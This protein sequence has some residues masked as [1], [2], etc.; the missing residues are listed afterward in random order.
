MNLV[1][2]FPFNPIEFRFCG[3]KCVDNEE[4]LKPRKVR[5]TS[6][7]K[8]KYIYA[9]KAL[10]FFY[11][12]FYYDFCNNFTWRE[13]NCRFALNYFFYE[14]KKIF[15][16][17]WNTLLTET[18]TIVNLSF[19]FLFCLHYFASYLKVIALWSFAYLSHQ[20]QKYTMWRID[21][22]RKS[23]HRTVKTERNFWCTQT[24]RR[25]YQQLTVENN[26]FL[27]WFSPNTHLSCH[28][29]KIYCKYPLPAK[30]SPY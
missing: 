26:D 4:L 24:I 2:I 10:D 12:F 16:F 27:S 21:Q 5:N 17:C 23:I 15:F 19:V 3:V 18:F 14:K 8:Y 25:K 7:C 11:H 13:R 30:Q 9:C 6:L 28:V 20:Q 29:S 1:E 22:S